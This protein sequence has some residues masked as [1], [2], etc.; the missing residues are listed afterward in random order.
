MPFV[1]GQE[2]WVVVGEAVVLVGEEEGLSCGAFV[3]EGFVD[4]VCRLFLWVD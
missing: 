3:G 2:G 4:A 1:E